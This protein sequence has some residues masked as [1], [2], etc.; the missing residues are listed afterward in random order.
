M[1]GEDKIIMHLCNTIHHF[2]AVCTVTQQ[3][4]N[5]KQMQENLSIRNIS[6]TTPQLQEHENELNINL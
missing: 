5:K 4:S 1:T 2:K 3:K 6:Y